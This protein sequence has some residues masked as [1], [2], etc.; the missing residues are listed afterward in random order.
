MIDI[1]GIR[2]CRLGT[3]DL[4]TTVEFARSVIGLE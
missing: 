2:Y 1:V 3:A 4:D